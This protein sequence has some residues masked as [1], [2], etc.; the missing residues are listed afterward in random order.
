MV[1]FEAR[2]L[3]ETFLNS[4]Q[5]QKMLIGEVDFLKPAHHYFVREVN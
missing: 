5:I 3:T 1:Y 2:S 4:Q